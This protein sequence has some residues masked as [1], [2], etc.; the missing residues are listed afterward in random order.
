MRK[1]VILFF[2]ISI[3]I[4]Y[5]FGQLRKDFSEDKQKFAEEIEEYV[6]K[7]LNDES[8]DFLE[9][10]LEKWLEDSVYFEGEYDE[11]TETCNLLLN[12]K[13]RPLHYLDYF[14][15]VM[16]FIDNQHDKESFTNWKEGLKKYVIGDKKV[17]L[18]TLTRFLQNTIDLV[19]SNIIYQSSSVIW[20]A[21]STNF[22]YKNDKTI[23]VDFSE[24]ELV[25]LAKRDSIEVFET[26]GKYYP[27]DII[28]KGDKALLTW[29]RAAYS[30]DEV[31]ANLPAYQ[32]DMKKSEFEVDSVVFTNKRYF[33][34]TLFG[35]VTY[36]VKFT[37]T[38]ENAAYPQFDSYKT[39]FVIN[40]LYE[41]VTFKGGF[42]MQGAK[43]VGTGTDLEP[44]SIDIFRRDT[45]VL[46]AKSNYFV[47]KKD[48]VDGVRTSVNIF[49]DRD[50]IF[51]P[52]LNFTYIVNNRQ[53]S[54]IRTDDFTSQSPYFN[55]YH[56]VD[57][58]FEQLSWSIDDAEIRFTMLPGS[59]IGSANFESMN[60][61]SHDRFYELQ[62]R[63]PEHPLYI[64]KT[65]AAGYGNDEFPVEAL[66]DYMRK[67]I[68][69]VQQL[70][71]RLSFQG[72]I[73]YDVNTET[74]TAKQKLYD[75]L[76]ASIGRI[77]YDVLNISSATNAPLD[78]AIYNTENKDIII[79]G[80]DHI[81][82]SDSQ[83]VNI[84]PYN[85]QVI[86]KQDRNFQF[87]GRV[88]AGL[89]S[90]YGSNFLFNYGR[91]KI[92]LQN[93]DSLRIRYISNDL[94]N[95]GNP[96]IYDV[97]SKIENLTG[98]VLIDEPD[99]KSGVK[100][101]PRYPIFRSLETSY[102]YYDDP[103]IK[104]GAYNRENFYFE[105]E[106]FELDSLDNFKKEG[107]TYEGVL[108]SGGIFPDIPQTLSIQPDNSLGFVQDTDSSSLPLYGGKGTFTDRLTLNNS[109]LWGNGKLNYLTSV[110]KSPEI[111]FYID[112]VNT[113]AENFEIVKKSTATE[114]PQ[115]NSRNDFIHWRPY[116]DSL[117]AYQKNVQF[118]MF[119]DSTFLEGDLTLTPNGLAGNG[120][121]DLKNAEI[122]SNGFVYE[123][124]DIHAQTSD[125]YLKSM[126][127]TGFTVLSENVSTHIDYDNSQ[128]TFKSNED[129]SI[130]EFPENKYIGFV[131]HFKWFM[132]DKQLQLSSE[133]FSEA[134]AK[135]DTTD[136]LVGALYVSIQPDQD[137]LSFVSPLANYNYEENL[138]N[139]EYVKYIEV[140]D[141]KI[142]PDE[143]K[144]TVA[145]NARIHTLTNAKIEANQKTKYH[146]IHT[147]SV[148]IFGKYDYT[149]SGKYDYVD[150]LGEI[151]QIHFDAITLDD[152]L[153]TIASGQIMANEDF[154]LS[155]N[156]AYQGKVRLAANREFLTFDGSTQ[157]DH[158][159]ELIGNNWLRFESE[160]NPLDI[161]IPIP[162]QPVDINGSN[163]FNG[164]MMANDSIHLFSTFF[165]PRKNYS[166]SYIVTA[167][168][169]LQYDKSSELYRVGAKEK[170]DSFANP[171]DYISF[172]R[173]ACEHYGEGKINLGMDL[174]QV[175]FSSV[176]NVRRD[177]NQNTTALNLM[178]ASDFF[179]TP[180][181]QDIFAATLDSLPGNPVDLKRSVYT[182]GMME[183]LGV[184]GYNAYLEEMRLFGFV[185][186]LP[187][188]LQ[189]TIV[190]NDLKLEWNDE[191][192]SYI[193][194]GEIG[195][196]SI[197]STQ[198]NKKYEGFMEI[199]R[200][201]SGDT[202]DFYIKVNNNTW[203]YFG[204]TRG[205]MQTLSTNSEYIDI[206]KNLKP[207]E[208]KSKI[209]ER[210]GTSYIYMLS[211]DKKKNT[212]LRRMREVEEM[213][214][215]DG[216]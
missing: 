143:G 187:K 126:K 107:L 193:S 173:E 116:Q 14:A 190:F 42:S 50:S 128:G 40:N 17:T 33:D 188:A 141:A 186:E 163:L 210:G 185:K 195:I 6:G 3:H 81:F 118:N 44:A 102:V 162:A 82:L 157:I 13:A 106:S 196:G 110:T 174:G 52:D 94:D 154:S 64:I 127:T 211:T 20:Q 130:V 19:S 45:V 146:L 48:R 112:S 145:P 133:E 57:M 8:E 76:S 11:I 131:D 203:F 134:E 30:R 80:V 31:F 178:L 137:S 200:K 181:V 184:E 115:V 36:K 136:N 105:L 74:I 61:F 1:L 51:H 22:S 153:Q 27:L 75:Y 4:N 142:F 34:Y 144:V 182:K 66:A 91:F 206:V 98:E 24:T 32:I 164:V 175:K 101:Y 125:F 150:E 113:V 16:A 60:Y 132:L 147:A 68:V 78:N 169:Y 77:D 159:C 108:Y 165:S 46:I 25:C 55:S 171:G 7:N 167:S 158:N 67:P 41:N 155:P 148:S 53:L 49:I 139:A 197:G 168:G 198:I 29:E 121:M 96:L 111:Q 84:Y 114:Y 99:N 88:D 161:L 140:A 9:M 103:S 166:D 87:D 95:Y 15:T 69:Q 152:S 149:G 65:F 2:L 109:G 214:T 189:H 192:N 124:N 12:R 56:K 85:Q 89:F 86:L 172:H 43:L 201:R 38:P 160:I 37:K 212:F 93:I 63:D 194:V 135:S 156:Y 39:D 180:A 209:K 207:K 35:K 199:V 54:L 100:S 70:L 119:N 21:R 151:Q 92:N 104:G 83:S 179:L 170:L 208:R 5:S 216:L 47:F 120:K 204:Y 176:G 213:R 97:E 28:W 73:Y 62:M 117:Y 23:Y 215:Q 191:S 138:I 123:E 59:S 129:F 72:F 202:F 177:I 205:V 183:I 122:V 71:M 58:N 26:S 18:N 10:F 90:F 79:N